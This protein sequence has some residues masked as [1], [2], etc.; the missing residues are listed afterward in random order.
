MW[1]RG[2]KFHVFSLNSQETFRHLHIFCFSHAEETGM[3]QDEKKRF[4]CLPLADQGITSIMTMSSHWLQDNSGNVVSLLEVERKTLDVSKPDSAADYHTCLCQLTATTTTTMKHCHPQLGQE[5][6]QNLSIL[7][8]RGKEI[9][10]DSL[11]NS[12]LTGWTPMQNPI[13]SKQLRSMWCMGQRQLFVFVSLGSE[14]PQSGRCLWQVPGL[15]H[16]DG[17]HWPFIQ[18]MSCLCTPP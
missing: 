9:N 12:K 10:Q 16:M 11:S 15:F 7:L 1:S 17:E 6:L 3:S 5:D 14:F 2:R 4:L 8:S 18:E 13:T